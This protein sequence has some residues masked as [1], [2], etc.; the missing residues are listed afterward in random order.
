M[1]VTPPRL[2]KLDKET[3]P[4][5]NHTCS[6]LRNKRTPIHD[7]SCDYA[8]TTDH[9]RPG[10]AGAGKA[11][12]PTRLPGQGAPGEPLRMSS[13]L[14]SRRSS[15]DHACLGKRAQEVFDPIQIFG[16]GSGT[17][18]GC[19][20]VH[21]SQGTLFGCFHALLWFPAG[22]GTLLRFPPPPAVGGRPPR[23]EWVR[24]GVK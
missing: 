10:T 12:A 5:Q 17:T 3:P 21:G 13:K 16:A 20:Q 2:S 14:D 8:L 7:Q 19:C 4:T 1:D 9:P 24:A 15:R 23:L 18:A 22:R 6:T 11:K